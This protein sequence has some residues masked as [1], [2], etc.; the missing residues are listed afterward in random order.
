[1]FGGGDT[2]FIQ[3][4][5]RSVNGFCFLFKDIGRPLI[6]DRYSQFPQ[7]VKVGIQPSS[8]YHIPSGGIDLC[9]SCSCRKRSGKKNG[10]TQCGTKIFRNGVMFDFCTAYRY[11]VSVPIHFCSQKFQSFQH[12]IHITDLRDIVHNDFFRCEKTGGDHGQ[13]GIFI[14]AYGNGAGYGAAAVD[15][16]TAHRKKLL[17]K[18]MTCFSSEYTAKKSFFKGSNGKDEKKPGGN[19]LSTEYFLLIFFI[20][21]PR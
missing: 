6:I 13:N 1:M 4:E 8:A 15:D 16:K 17:E 19:L 9:P 3:K 12:D 5:I 14:A 11:I 21:F 7:A 20:L 10:G 2:G 18:N